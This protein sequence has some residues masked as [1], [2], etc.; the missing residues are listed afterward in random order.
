[1]KIIL[2]RPV[3]FRDLHGTVL[4][5]YPVGT[6]LDA[7]ADTGHYFIT[8]MGGIYHTEARLLEPLP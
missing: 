2:T 4:C 6:V 3:T 1:M 7:T 8:S 5:H